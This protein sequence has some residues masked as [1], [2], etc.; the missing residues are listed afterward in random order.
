MREIDFPYDPKKPADREGR[1]PNATNNH[2]QLKSDGSNGARIGLATIAAVLIIAF[3]FFLR[4]FMKIEGRTDVFVFFLDVLLPTAAIHTGIFVLLAFGFRMRARGILIFWIMSAAAL[5]FWGGWNAAQ[6]LVLILILGLFLTLIGSLLT[7]HLLLPSAHGWGISLAFG[8]ALTSIAGAFLAWAHIFYWWVLVLAMLAILVPGFR[9][10][11]SIYRAQI[12]EAWKSLVSGWNLPFAFTIQG[13]FLLGVYAFVVA[14][15]PETNSDA[16]RFYWPYMKLLSHYAGF[17]DGPYQWSYILPQGGAV[18]GATVLVLLGRQVVRLSMLLVWAA[19]IGIVCRRIQEQ[20]SSIQCAVAL[21]VA[22]CPVVLW[23]SSSLMQDIFACAFVVVLA[24]LCATGSKPGFARFWGAIGIAL[25]GACAAKHTTLAYG[26]PLVAYASIRSFKATGWKSTLRGLAVATIAFLV[27]LSP[28]LV[29]SYQQSGNPAFPF[30]TKIFPSPIWPQGVAFSSL[31]AFKLPSGWRGWILWPIDLTY[32]T[33]KFVEG[34]DGKLGLTLIVILLVAVPALWRS[35]AL[36]RGL[37]ICGIVGTGLLWSQTAYLRYWLPGLWLCAIG[38]CYFLTKHLRSIPARS[39][40]ACAAFVIMIPQVLQSMLTYW[41][42]AR[43]WPWDVYS[44]RVTW[45]GFLGHQFEDLA[46]ELNRSNVLKN[47]SP[48]IWVTGCEEAGH[49]EVQPMDAAVWELRLHT[50]GPRSKAEY[51]GSTGCKYW[52]VNEDDQ[53]AYWLQFEGITQLFW[54][55]ANLVARAGSLAM[56]RMPPAEGV[57]REFDARAAAGTDLLTNGG[58]EVPP[59]QKPKYWLVDGAA[60]WLNP[61]IEAHEGHGC[62]Q[63]GA[64]S[65]TQQRIA[66][67]PG[68]KEV[69]LVAYARSRQEGQPGSLQFQLATV[70]FP[71]DPSKVPLEN[72]VQ[73]ESYLTGKQETIS[74]SGQWQ[75]FRARIAIPSLTRYVVVGFIQPGDKGEVLVDSAHLYS[76]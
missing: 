48:K 57:L 58:F 26:V 68:V 12:R 62:I 16:I 55:D 50:L 74:I 11:L 14:M 66:L 2:A 67:P 36:A 9:S 63:L 53:E 6:G 47:E 64:N 19:L 25:A 5:V 60:K 32:H 38:S 29:H 7:K 40:V 69:E 56:Y 17:F 54:N 75:E 34:F 39:I 61:S 42:D 18:Y 22:S 37:V 71:K 76:R 46:T 1:M 51:L 8:I 23:V 45:L 43:G 21:I 27:A 65:R 20:Y 35:G 59:G 13:L 24:F 31:D 44:H 72:Q 4:L 52:L 41:P 3:T 10:G 28:W 70:G 49:L 15:A 33:H 73:P 30:L